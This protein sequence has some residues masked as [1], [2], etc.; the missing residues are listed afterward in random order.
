M[1]LIFWSETQR[2]NLTFSPKLNHQ[3]VKNADHASRGLCALARLLVSL[4]HT[5]KLVTL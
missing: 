3:P 2:F 4:S 5:E 1:V